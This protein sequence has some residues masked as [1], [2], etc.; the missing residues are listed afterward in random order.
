MPHITIDYTSGLD[1]D[2]DMR[3]LADAVHD[4]ACRSGVFPIGGVRTLVRQAQYSRVADRGDGAGFV[5]ISVRI[6]PGRSTE[7]KT[8]VARTLFEAA[9]SAMSAVFETRDDVA[10]QL[11]ITEFDRAMTLSRNKMIPSPARP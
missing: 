9:A 6:A 10:L 1:A 7:T 5:Q 3:A 2:I 8:D 11:E 4:S